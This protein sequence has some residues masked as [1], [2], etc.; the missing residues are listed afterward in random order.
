VCDFLFIFQQLRQPVTLPRL[1]QLRSFTGNHINYQTR[2]QV[3]SLCK[4]IRRA[5]TTSPIESL[6]L[7]QDDPDQRQLAEVSSSSSAAAA[8]S[9]PN[10]N[11]GAHISFRSLID[12]LCSSHSHTL[13]ILDMKNEYI[14]I[15]SLKKLFGTCL[16]LEE[17]YL[18]V[19]RHSLV[20][21]LTPPPSLSKNP[22]KL[23]PLFQMTFKKHASSLHK[24]HTASFNIRNIRL[25]HRHIIIDIELITAIMKHGPPLLRRLSVNGQSWEVRHLRSPLSSLHH[26]HF[27]FWL[28]VCIQS[29]WKPTQDDTTPVLHIHKYYH[30]VLPWDKKHIEPSSP[31]PPPPSSSEEE[32]EESLQTNNHHYPPLTQSPPRPTPIP[33]IADTPATQ[34]IL[35]TPHH[36]PSKSGNSSPHVR[37]REPQDLKSK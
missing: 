37:F 10:N 26:A 18:C 34:S 15:Q 28:C 31:I 24:L 20:R 35:T 22:N 13:T 14:D 7:I 30:P 36:P 2:P 12:H 17:I 1:K 23:I 33:S 29:S 6:R 32:E 27:F 9:I 4:W 21:P 11:T 5:I 19:G 8:S 3:R 16:A 25:A